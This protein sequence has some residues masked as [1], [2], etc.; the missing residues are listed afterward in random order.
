MDKRE[1][2]SKKYETE[3][4]PKFLDRVTPENFKEVQKEEETVEDEVIEK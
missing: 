4:K 3:D 2:F 1:Y